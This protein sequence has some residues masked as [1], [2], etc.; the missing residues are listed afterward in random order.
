MNI[1]NNLT[2]LNGL[3]RNI[4]LDAKTLLTRLG[5]NPT[6]S[7]S[8]CLSVTLPS[9]WREERQGGF[10][11]VFYGPEGQELWSFIKYDPWDRHSFLQ[12]RNVKI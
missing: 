10:H 1:S 8:I 6:D 7:G 4:D 11:T 5:F 3:T 9:G 12:A 2:E